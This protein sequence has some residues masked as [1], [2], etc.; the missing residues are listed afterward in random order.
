MDLIITILPVVTKDLPI[1][2]K[3]DHHLSYVELPISD[4]SKNYTTVM[5]KMAQKLLLILLP[6]NKRIGH[7]K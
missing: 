7:T 5:K 4:R 2:D 6:E 1:S 3:S